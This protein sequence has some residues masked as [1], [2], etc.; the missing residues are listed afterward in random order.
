VN[1]SGRDVSYVY[2]DG[3][4]GQPVQ[5]G[6]PAAEEAKEPS[7]ADI[8]IQAGQAMSEAAARTG[9]ALSDATKRT[10]KCLGT[11]LKGC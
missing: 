3:V 4:A 6:S 8:T 9:Q 7:L 10:L 1:C 11:A 2:Q 5:A